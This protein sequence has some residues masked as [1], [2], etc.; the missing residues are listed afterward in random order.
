MNACNS[1]ATPGKTAGAETLVLPCESR[2][3]KLFYHSDGKTQIGMGDL[4]ARHAP[5]K[6]VRACLL[7][8]VISISMKGLL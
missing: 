5:L 3:R 6:G 2:L 7:G 8:T 4:V 1:E